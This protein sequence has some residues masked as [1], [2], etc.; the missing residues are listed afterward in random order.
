[1]CSPIITKHSKQRMHER[2]GLKKKIC[3]S[4]IEKAV[5]SGTDIENVRGELGRWAR[6]E[7]RE[8]IIFGDKL[9][10]MKKN[11]VVTV[12]QVPGRYVSELERINS[13]RKKLN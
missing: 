7:S 13:E 6:R 8:G 5:S 9:F 2:A 1:M 11:I 4:A 12:L 10:V 3:S